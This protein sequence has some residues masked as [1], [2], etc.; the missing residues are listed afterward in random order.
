MP[1][2]RAGSI[3]AF[4]GAAPAPESSSDATAPPRKDR[5]E[6]HRPQAHRPGPAHRP[7]RRRRGALPPVL[8]MRA[9]APRLI[10][11][12]LPIALFVAAAAPMIR[13]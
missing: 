12:A 8:N 2:D 3:V 5:H 9:I 13:F 10:G 11:L 1:P 7:L 4:I 6:G